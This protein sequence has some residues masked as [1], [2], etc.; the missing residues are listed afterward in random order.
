MSYLTSIPRTQ[1]Q[2]CFS[3][4]V[5][6]LCMFYVSRKEM[7]YQEGAFKEGVTSW[8]EDLSIQSHCGHHRIQNH[9]LFQ[10]RKLL[11]RGSGSPLHII[12]FPETQ[13]CLDCSW[14]GSSVKKWSVLGGKVKILKQTDFPIKG[15]RTSTEFKSSFILGRHLVRYSECDDLKYFLCNVQ[16]LR[17]NLN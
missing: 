6:I 2:T 15:R 11:G 14:L 16:Q 5:A 17:L 3:T 9:L 10:C 13:W 1:A 7:T 8:I 12:I 4:S